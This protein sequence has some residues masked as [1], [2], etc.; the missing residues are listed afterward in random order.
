M[1]ALRR[2]D[3]FADAVLQR[4]ARRR[5]WTWGQPFDPL[6]G[7]VVHDADVDR[8]IA[9]L[10]TSRATAPDEAKPDRE[11]RRLMNDLDL[12][13][14]HARTA[15]HTIDD[16]DPFGA[17]V[18]AAGL[19]RHGVE[20]L[21]LTAAVGWNPVRLRL[22][23]YVQDDLSARGVMVAWVPQLLGDDA[24][25]LDVLAP[26][27][28]LRRSCL[29]EVHEETLPGSA[30][31]T[32]P[33]SVQW[34]LLADPSRDPDLP[35]DAIEYNGEPVGKSPHLSLVHGADRIRRLQSAAELVGSS[36]L[37]VSAEPANHAEWAAVVRTALCRRSAAVLEVDA[38]SATARNWIART[39]MVPWVVSTRFPVTL[40]DLPPLSFT[41]SEASDDLV[42]EDE[43]RAALGEVPEGH[44]LSAQQLHLLSRLENSDP[45]TSLR[46]LASGELDRLARRVRPRRT[47]D[48]LVLSPER[49]AQVR[50]VVIRVRHRTQVFDQWGFKAIPSAGVLALFSGPS[51][52]G[53][54]MSAEI[55]AGE[56]GLDMFKVDL[57]ALVSKYI[58]ETE[59]NLERVFN[60]AEGGGVVLVFDE[61]D[62]VFGKRTQVSDAQDRYANIETSYLLQRLEGYDGLVV[63][64]SNYAGNIDQAFMRRIHVAVE[65]PLPEAGER[66]AIWTAAFPDS[67]PMGDIDFNFLAEKFK[68][69]GGSIR[70]AALTAAFSAADLDT[71]VGM[72]HA[73]HGVRREYQKLGRIVT[74]G[75]FG[76]WFNTPLYQ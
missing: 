10:P 4:A 26:D 66:L 48:E 74:P 64:T 35:L 13:V 56:L 41:E 29:I 42:D 24:A 51:G 62:A 49:L 15:L 58:G 2:W 16:A 60:A 73:I 28:A 9:E 30:V 18:R 71:P 57:S 67:A 27:G 43:V 61:A 45:A 63:L 19:D 54:T 75:E 68:L 22:L 32:V 53:K 23:G 31:I 5:R 37:L 70:T 72:V 33:L 40:E 50:E 3:V 44:R 11:R 1:A 8:L 34:Y 38:V 20:V 55:I 59:K 17:L 12:A 14:E 76:Q 6:A 36:R 69:A 52:T 25:A 39:W 46:R 7:S 21:A 47:W 65:F